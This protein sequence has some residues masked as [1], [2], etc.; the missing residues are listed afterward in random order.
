MDELSEKAVKRCGSL[1][2]IRENATDVR[3]NW[4]ES[5]EPVIATIANRFRR[6][7]LHDR[8]IEVMDTI[9]DDDIDILKRH[10]REL[11]PGLDLSKV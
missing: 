4:A 8:N 3:Q 6:L 10:A 7:K 1:K 5:V 2:E 9:P 11:F